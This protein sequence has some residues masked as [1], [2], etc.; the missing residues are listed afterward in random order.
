MIPGK[1]SNVHLDFGIK[2]RLKLILG[3][4]VLEGRGR[5]II[6]TFSRNSLGEFVEKNLGILSLH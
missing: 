5:Y 4:T 6:G 1:N 2:Q 3:S